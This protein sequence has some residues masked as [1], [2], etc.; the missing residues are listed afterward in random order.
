[1]AEPTSPPAV[2]DPLER[3]PALAAAIVLIL[4]ISAHDVFPAHPLWWIAIAVAASAASLLFARREFFSCGFLAAA[5]FFVSLACAQLFGNFYS[6]NDIGSFTTDESRLV[7]LETE[8][9]DPP[10][11]LRSATARGIGSGQRQVTRARVLR[12]LTQNGWTTASGEVLLNISEPVQGLA[13]R[14]HV[15]VLGMLHRPTPAMNPGQFDW[16]RYY[17]DQRI[18]AAVSVAR[19]GAVKIQSNPGP[20]VLDRL[21]AKSR[22]L[23]AAGFDE[24]QSVDHA[25]LRALV[26][27]DSDPELRDVQEE[28]RRT[29]TSHHLAIS[30]M[31][32]AILGGMIYA[33]CLLL[34]VRPRI[35]VLISLAAVW[36]YGA[37]VLP[38][39]PVLRSVILCTTFGIGLLLRRNPDGVQLLSISAIAL[40]VCQPMDLYNAGFQ[41]SFGTVLGLMLFTHYVQPKIFP[42]DLDE[43]IALALQGARAPWTLR[44]KH[45]FRGKVAA[46]LASGLVA[47]AVSVP[48]VMHHFEQLNPWAIF[49]SILL[50]PFVL[51]ALVGGFLKLILTLLV[52]GL[53]HWWAAMAGFFIAQMRHALDALAKLPGSDFPFPS[54]SLWMVVLIYALFAIPFLP[55]S[56]PRVRRTSRFGPLVAVMLIA[57]LPFSAGVSPARDEKLTVTV[58]SVGAGM[59]CVI[60]LPNGQTALV[61]DGSA[62]IED[63]QRKCLGPFLR[64][65]YRRSVECMF[66][67]HRDYDHISAA[68]ATV[69]AYDIRRIFVGDRFNQF[70]S[71]SAPAR[72]LVDFL[73]RRGRV[74][75]TLVAGNLVPLA[76]RAT[77]ETLWPTPGI[78][79]DSNDSGLVLRLSYAGRSILFPADIQAPAESALL[80]GNAKLKSD[81][82]IAPHH[83]S[84]EVT[85]AD[86]LRAVGPSAIIS[87][88]DHTLTQKQKQ[89]ERIASGYR[90]Y[91]TDR[92]GAVT[93]TITAKGKLS[94]SSFID[95]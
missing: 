60:E 41:L 22:E 75:K 68:A 89:F 69:D 38:S 67:S 82:L 85:T 92:C 54:P 62:T 78:N 64:H 12:V 33:I 30:G 61:D 2:S 13:I 1:M 3:R 71:Q 57:M 10:R 19:A 35:S 43:Q 37:V 25:L 42:P 55:W 23:L 70:A 5:I 58:L 39:P 36:L 31:H 17:R 50:V 48:M 21:R 15:R 4:G 14:Q 40:L 63:L 95:N 11:T 53:A 59:C 9:I 6:S 87:S 72:N 8:I 90:L 49:A 74:P 29:G 16:A 32:I 24:R 86:F 7:Q 88:N 93:I 91:R 45:W 28:F 44:L 18:C 83:G 76:R 79:F 84:A 51:C 56:F 73:H 77:I 47:W 20:T 94:V 27:G 80:T 81:V 66:L 52:P 26:L 34:R 65:E 46:M